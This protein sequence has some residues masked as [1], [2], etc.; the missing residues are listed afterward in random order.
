MPGICQASAGD[1]PNI[2]SAKD[3]DIHRASLLLS[4]GVNLDLHGNE[5]VLIGDAT[6]F[7]GRACLSV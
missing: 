1:Q 7:T 5:A 3:G 4:T 6:H 2:A